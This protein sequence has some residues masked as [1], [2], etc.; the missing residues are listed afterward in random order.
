MKLGAPGA[1]RGLL[2][3]WTGDPD[4]TTDLERA[5]AALTAADACLA[6][7]GPACPAST[8]KRLQ[9]NV[10]K[11]REVLPLALDAVIVAGLRARVDC[12]IDLHSIA[13]GREALMRRSSA[14]TYS[15]LTGWREVAYSGEIVPSLP[16]VNLPGGMVAHV[17]CCERC[18][19]V[20]LRAR[21]ARRCRGCASSRDRSTGTVREPRTDPLLPW[22]VVGDAMRTPRVCEVCSTP[23]LANGDAKTCGTR[24]RV[25]R[26]RAK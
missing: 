22:L 12:W 24:C 26:H 2:D 19:L 3:W 5:F 7:V 20:E 11:A 21:D 18:G 13:T 23:F 6:N 10:D 1:T 25:D 8:L 17:V 16:A 9:D 4:T 15:L 14:L